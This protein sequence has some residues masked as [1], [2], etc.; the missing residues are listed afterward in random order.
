MRNG[1]RRLRIAAHPASSRNDAI[2]R[3]M[4]ECVRWTLILLSAPALLAQGGT[5][6]KPKPEDYE[7]HA[8]ATAT[9]LWEGSS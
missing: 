2:S 3:G 9:P 7:A 4:I 8:K 1:P 5:D 6:P